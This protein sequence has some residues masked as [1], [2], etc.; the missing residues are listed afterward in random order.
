MA[1][2]HHDSCEC[3]KSELDLFSLPMT[4]TSIESGQWMH[5]MPIA[6]LSGSNVLEFVVPGT[7]D[8]YA[9][10]AHTLL[11]VKFKLTD[12]A[13]AP[14]A[15]KLEVA[16]V[17]NWGHTAFSQVHI[18]LN[19]KNVTS[20]SDTYPYRAYFET[21]LTYGRPA[22][23]SHL[24]AQL[25]YPDTAGKFD[26]RTSANTGFAKRQTFTQKGATVDMIF[27][28]HCDLFHQEKYLLNGVEMKVKLVRSK[29]EFHL[30]GKSDV[31]VRMVIE[32]ATLMVRKVRISPSVLIAHAKAL[33]KSSAKYAI[34]RADVKSL[35]ITEGLRSKIL[36][37]IYLGQLPKR[38]IL[39]FVSNNAFNGDLTLNPFKFESFG[40]NF[41]SLYVDGTQ[42]PAYP[43]T[44]AFGSKPQTIRSYHSL[45]SGTG[46]HFRDQGND[47]SREDYVDGNVLYAFDLTPD[48]SSHTGQWTLQKTGSMRLEVRFKDSLT[49]SINCI[50][51]SEFD[52]LIEIDKHRNVQTDFVN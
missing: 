11:H 50:L 23:T 25:W 44:P 2:V 40:I 28:L 26:D 17:N 43:L 14:I 13:G 31:K 47:I 39:G 9:D 42:V 24:T 4:Q 49:S 32:S 19:Q 15:D 38:V 8:E 41:L 34:V 1:F 6:P 33:E 51:Y 21:L 5:Y 45:F 48:L 46:I 7:G 18:S 20:S 27:N 37:N 52:S 16:P 22:K 35:T 30:I 36:D 29:D 12:E 3:T 10:L